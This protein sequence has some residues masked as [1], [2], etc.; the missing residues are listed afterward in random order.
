MAL[1]TN[2]AQD[3]G[4]VR[5]RAAGRLGVAGRSDCRRPKL[6]LSKHL[7]PLDTVSILV[8]PAQLLVVLQARQRTGS[9]RSLDSSIQKG[10]DIHNFSLVT[11]PT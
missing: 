3:C 6:A 7:R 11:F 4:L 1:G 5:Q 10:E 2:G 8:F 9:R